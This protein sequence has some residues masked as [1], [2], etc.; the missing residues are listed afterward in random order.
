MTP[1]ADTATLD[2]LCARL[3]KAPYVTVDTEFMR[4]KTYWPRL[5]LVQVAGPDEA[6][7]IDPLAP[8][9]DLAFDETVRGEPAGRGKNLGND[10]LAARR[11][12]R[13]RGDVASAAE[14]FLKGGADSFFKKER[15]QVK[16]AHGKPSELHAFCVIS[17]VLGCWPETVE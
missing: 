12:A 2:A 7:V 4:D 5:C 10:R 6:A 9:L 3:S 17:R 15:G 16:V 11:D 8:G 13:Q 1:L 14:V